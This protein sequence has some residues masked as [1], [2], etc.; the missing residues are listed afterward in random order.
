GARVLE[1]RGAR[2]GRVLLVRPDHAARAALDPPGGVG[3]RRAFD[4]AAVVRDRGLALVERNA[5]KRD[6]LV[7][8]AP[9]NQPARNRLGL[10]R[11]PRDQPAAVFDELV[12][13]ELDRLNAVIAED[14]ERR[15]QEA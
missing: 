12:T 13:D 10:A 9:E 8:D 11:R 3:A 15:G 14:R 5:G 6:A 1:Q 2:L 7:A 4:P